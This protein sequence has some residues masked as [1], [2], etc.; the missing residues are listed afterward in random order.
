M[1]ANT[2]ERVKDEETRQLLL[3]DTNTID[4][5]LNYI[6]DLL[7]SMLDMNKAQDGK[8]TLD[9]GPADV[10]RDIL[11]P[12]KA[13]LCKRGAQVD[14]EAVGPSDLV[15]MTDKL[16]LKQIIGTS[17]CMKRVIVF[18]VVPCIIINETGLSHVRMLLSSSL[19]LFLFAQSI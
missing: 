6:N 14:V 17:P 3:D 5:S 13:I 12:V 19:S 10:L 11:Q 2:Q 16:R 4:S 18:W 9:E 1:S 8:I 7:R 15:V